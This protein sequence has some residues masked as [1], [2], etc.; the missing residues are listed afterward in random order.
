[1]AR[2][3]AATAFRKSLADFVARLI[4][5]THT[6][7]ILYD[8]VFCESFQSWLVAATSSHLRSFR[9]TAT[10][11][12]LDLV[13][14]ICSTAA[15]VTKAFAAA[16]RQRDAEAKK[17]RVD[18]AKLKSYE[19]RI[20]ETHRQK[21]ALETY[22]GDLFDGVWVHRYRDAEPAIRSECIRALGQW[23]RGH[24]DHYL[25]GDFLRY[26]GWILTDPSKEARL[27]AVRSLAALYGME[28]YVGTLQ[29]F[30]ERFK[31]RLVEMAEAEVDLSV[32]CAAIEVLRAIDKHGLLED[33][34]RDSLARLVFSAEPRVRKSAAAFF[35]TL[36]EDAVEQRT[37]DLQAIAGGAGKADREREQAAR[38]E[39]RVLAAL[40]VEHGS[41]V[42]MPAG[43]ETEV[44]DEGEAATA[45]TELPLISSDGQS[46]IDMAIEVLAAH[47]GP[48]EDAQTLI[49]YLLVERDE[50]EDA[51]KPDEA[52]EVMLVSILVAVARKVVADAAVPSKKAEAD[53]DETVAEL[54]RALIKA[55]PR[56]IARY[57]SDEV[58]IADVLALVP[59]L[60][61]EL[62]LDLRMITAYETL[63]DD[64]ARQFTSHKSPATLDAALGAIRKMLATV[65][66]GKSNATKV[67]ELELALIEALREAAAGKQLETTAFDDEDRDALAA[68][69]ARLARLA[70]V[71]D[72]APAIEDTG[73]LRY[74]S[75][76][77][78]VDA[79]ADRGRLGFADEDGLIES[80]LGILGYY[81]LWSGR[82]AD[83]DLDAFRARRAE[84][85]ERLTDL[86]FGEASN[87]TEAVRR[88][89]FV[90]L[91]ELYV[92]YGPRAGTLALVFP[93][94]AQFRCAGFIQSEIERTAEALGGDVAAEDEDEDDEDEPAKRKAK[95]PVTPKSAKQRACAR[96]VVEAELMCDQA[97]LGR[98]PSWRQATSSPPRSPPLPVLS[99]SA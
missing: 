88:A 26:V 76:W 24:P 98:S 18:K 62:Y 61:L 12:A 9:H 74:T 95:A 44:E 63:W 64:V 69:L 68:W 32:R 16:T 42:G 66:L 73:G 7:E 92:I 48:I 51:L 89:A 1:M 4:D 87:A 27:E 15:S 80:A 78:I 58:K 11:I 25:S 10:I 29:H 5:A 45:R 97:A 82:S 75:A 93:E 94:E 54:T 91:L 90:R 77:T 3:Q 34:Q 83:E 81:T 84:L 36:V 6:A 47:I 52:E 38:L 43:V 20:E 22:L 39:L 57:Q 37:P 60:S 28:D 99:A 46:R 31:G 70:T 96:L 71:H 59:L 79:L 67:A 23:M 17:A 50:L 40:L 19:E 56:L 33:E 2:K 14:A 21:V 53:E 65:S 41:A 30:T 49:D 72:V 8:D 86:A 55:L 85:V 35:G 13:S